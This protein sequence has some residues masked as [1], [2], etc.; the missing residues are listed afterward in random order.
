MRRAFA[1]CIPIPFFIRLPARAK[2]ST[3]PAP[4]IRS[5]A[6]LAA[7]LAGGLDPETAV[8]LANIAAGIVVAKTGTAPISRNE[9]VA[10]F[11]ASTQ[12]KGPDKILDL[13]TSAGPFGG[14]AR[15]RRADRLYQRLF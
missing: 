10:E 7:S 6:T 5:I 3:L 15:E 1:F 4:A 2:Y 11:T 13:R 9:L 12:M 8:T 14:M